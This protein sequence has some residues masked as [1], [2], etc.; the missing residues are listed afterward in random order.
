[1]P[2]FTQA[3][4]SS[5]GPEIQSPTQMTLTTILQQEL[6]RCRSTSVDRIQGD[7]KTAETEDWIIVTTTCE[8]FEKQNAAH[9]SLLSENG[10]LPTDARGCP[11]LIGS[12]SL[13]D[14]SATSRISDF[15]AIGFQGVFS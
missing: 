10:V 14:A 9:F 7:R 13:R 8:H 3:F 12:Y 5:S 2:T 11:G 15:K 1:M 6:S 4:R